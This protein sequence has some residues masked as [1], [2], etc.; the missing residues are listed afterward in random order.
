MTNWFFR[1]ST[2][3]TE[4][5]ETRYRDVLRSKTVNDY[6]WID[7][8]NMKEV[9]DTYFEPIQIQLVEAKSSAMKHVAE[10]TLRI[11]TALNKQ[12]K[13]INLTLDTKLNELQN[14]INV[15]NTTKNELETKKNNLKWMNSIIARINKLINF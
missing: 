8:V 4:R 14:T 5:Y 7:Y 11:K 6:E 15:A 9:V 1:P 3:G 2:W 13:Q 10:E 12:L